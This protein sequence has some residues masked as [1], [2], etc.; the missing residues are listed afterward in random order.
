M[1][2]PKFMFKRAFG[3][4][5]NT[6]SNIFPNKTVGKNLI[7]L[8][9]TII[10]F[11]LIMLFSASSIKAY[12]NFG[13]SYY[14]LK[15]Q[16]FSLILGFVV[17]WFFSQIDYHKWKKYAFFMLIFSIALL[18]LVFIPGLSAEWGK[19]HSWI[20]IFSF[21]LQPSEFVKITFLLYLSA[22]L[23]SRKNIIQS[24]GPFLVVLGIIAFLMVLQPD[25]GTLFIIVLISLL[26]Y[27]VGGG[28]IKH[29]L[30]IILIGVLALIIIIHFKPYQAGRFKCL[31]DINYSQKNIC[32]QVNQSLIAVGSGG[33]IGRGLGASRQKY[34]YLPEVS[35]DSIF[36]VI[37]EELGLIFSTILIILYLLLFYHGVLIAKA[38]PDDF[39]KI[40]AMGIIGWIIFQALINIGGMINL[41]PMTGVP[42]PLISYGGSAIVA[43]LGAIGILVNISK[44]TID[45]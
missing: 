33:L 36:A 15:H 5:P 6:L 18:C 7:Y 12:N 14:F 9:S 38:A 30:F 41:I 13:D 20:K 42:L 22:W 28:S 19:A 16:I 39:G 8:V 40:L 3:D 32:Y 35:N 24:I 27:F 26:V 17:Y 43:I 29:I 4:R 37:S 44:Q 2:D 25:I 31:F 34:L 10:V 23:E 21:S 45:S 11:G 1:T